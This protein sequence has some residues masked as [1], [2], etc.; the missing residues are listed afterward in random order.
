MIPQ[1]HLMEEDVEHGHGFL[2]SLPQRHG[3][4]LR[5]HRRGGLQ[6]HV[7][8]LLTLLAH[9]IGFGRAQEAPPPGLVVGFQRILGSEATKV[10]KVS[11]RRIGLS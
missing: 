3:D 10:R 7:V 9:L 1:T 11:Q 5:A 8:D 6:Q 4:G 2:V